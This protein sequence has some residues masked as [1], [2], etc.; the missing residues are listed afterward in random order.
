MKMEH[1]KWP[2]MLLILGRSGTQYVAMATKLLSSN[3]IAHLLESYHKESSIS[4]RNWLS[5]YL[6]SSYLIKISLTVNDII[7]W[8][9]C[10]SKNLN[11]SGTKGDI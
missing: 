1:Q 10:T 6:F 4:D 5:R 11:I 7:T 9:I 3:C 8:L 2:E